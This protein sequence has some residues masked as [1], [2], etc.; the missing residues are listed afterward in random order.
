MHIETCP[1]CGASVRIDR[2]N[3]NDM[4]QCEYCN[5]YISGINASLNGVTNLV[6]GTGTGVKIS[7]SNTFTVGSAISRV[8]RGDIAK[9]CIRI[10][11]IIVV[12]LLCFT[13]TEK[14]ISKLRKSYA[15][16]NKTKITEPI[17]A[18]G[19]TVIELDTGDKENTI[20]VT[21]FNDEVSEEDESNVVKDIYL[22]EMLNIKQG[23]VKIGSNSGRT[24]NTGEE[25]SNYLYAYSPYEEIV[26]KL[27]GDYSR[28][29]GLWCI[30]SYSRNKDTKNGFCVYTDNVLAYESPIITR[31]DVPV[32]VDVDVTDCDILTIMFTEGDGDAVLAN[33]MV[34]NSGVRTA[35]PATLNPAVLPCWLTDMSSL[36]SEGIHINGGGSDLT[37]TGDIVSH[38]LSGCENGEIVYYLKGQYSTISGFLA[39]RDHDKNTTKH[40][41]VVIYADDQPVYISPLITG[42]DTPQY[43]DNIS[44]NNCEKLKIVFMGDG[45][46][47][48]VLSN[49]RVFP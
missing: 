40:S 48:A 44:I 9:R 15:K 10:F 16:K 36:T 5:A 33:A 1:H 32:P 20:S 18:V 11:L 14:T 7:K 22:T 31:G 25:Y 34:S 43:F 49:I 42:G 27:N 12:V 8:D 24:T 41:G 39:L 2:I 29:S 45:D 28:L 17:K 37:N 47:E 26:Y 35:N 3:Q 19:D 38:Y 30:D 13:I 46:W 23:S 21:E 6:D 4:Y